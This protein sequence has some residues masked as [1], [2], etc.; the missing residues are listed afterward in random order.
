[1]R[2]TSV[3]HKEELWNPGTAQQWK[4]LR[5]TSSVHY[6]AGK[7]YNNSNKDAAAVCSSGLAGDSRLQ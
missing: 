5:E 6:W 1:M 3:S 4:W 7:G 2:L